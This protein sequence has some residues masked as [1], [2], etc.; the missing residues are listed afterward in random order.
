MAQPAVSLPSK[1]QMELTWRE[2]MKATTK[3]Y[4]GGGQAS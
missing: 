1:I 2:G 3:P 4:G